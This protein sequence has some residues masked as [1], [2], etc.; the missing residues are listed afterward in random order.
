MRNGG[1]FQQ[2][3]ALGVSSRP[4][5]QLSLVIFHEYKSALGPG[6]LEGHIKKGHQNFIQHTNRVQLAG[7]FEK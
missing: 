6:E 5:P 7:S 3:F 4:Q 1:V 2:R